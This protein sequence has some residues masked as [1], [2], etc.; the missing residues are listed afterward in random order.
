MADNA[1]EQKSMLYRW[2]GKA[3]ENTIIPQIEDSVELAIQDV[4]K[5]NS[6]DD[7]SAEQKAMIIQGYEN[8]DFGI[9]NIGF[10]DMVNQWEN[11]D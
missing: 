5:V 4:F 10:I 9:M 2:M 3:A 1:D 7:L 6:S 11:E 8:E